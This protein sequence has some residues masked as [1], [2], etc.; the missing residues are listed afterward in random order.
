M[1]RLVLNVFV[2]LIAF[3]LHSCTVWKAGQEVKKNA[4]QQI[5]V[6]NNQLPSDY[7]KEY[8]GTLILL[9]EG[10]KYYDNLATKYFDKYYSGKYLVVSQEDLA[11]SEY[12]N[13]EEYRYI[14]VFITTGFV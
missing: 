8:D 12:S 2:V 9:T 7:M 1:K 6:Q 3:S 10:K 5:T 13:I 11:K 4:E 14:L